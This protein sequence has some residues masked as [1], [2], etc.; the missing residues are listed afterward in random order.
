MRHGA[1]W[2]DIAAGTTAAVLT[3]PVSMGYGLLTMYALGDAY[4]SHGVLAGLYSAILVPLVALL[5]GA[6]TAMMYAPR[7]VV[8]FLLSAIVLQDVARARP[9]VADP[10][11]VYGTLTVVFFI[12][13]GAGLFQMLF[14]IL[15]LGVLVKYIPSPVMAGFQN[16][17]AVLIFSSQLGPL[18]GLPR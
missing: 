18:L 11:D 12:V 1:V 4:L 8:A 13:L 2:T 10:A 17:A 5:L 9:P 3:I 7:S 6:R 15:R 16:A 14:G